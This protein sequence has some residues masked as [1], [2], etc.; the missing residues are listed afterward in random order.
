MMA[1]Q[2]HNG[3]HDAASD[4]YTGIHCAAWRTVNVPRLVRT[5]SAPTTAIS[6][7]AAAVHTGA[8]VTTRSLDLDHR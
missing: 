4:T 8:T 7:A 1:A 3:K 6:A 5:I 2:A